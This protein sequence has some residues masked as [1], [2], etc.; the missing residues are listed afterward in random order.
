MSS[1][2]T[3]NK[4]AENQKTENQIDPDS[5][6][7]SNADKEAQDKA[8]AT[9]QNTKQRMAS[10]TGRGNGGGDAPD[11]TN[12]RPEPDT[13]GER[14]GVSPA[15]N[16]LIWTNSSKDNW[17]NGQ[18]KFGDLLKQHGKVKRTTNEKK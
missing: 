9:E 16:D 7:P 5:T 2:K 10:R 15:E 1:K 6:A 18:P 14:E 13:L 17:N 12:R 11:R 4:K 8:T 3:E